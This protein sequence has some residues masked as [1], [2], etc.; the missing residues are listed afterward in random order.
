[1]PSQVPSVP[2][3]E[4]AVVAQR[5]SSVV[6]GTFEQTPSVVAPGNAHDLHVP[7]QS[8]A[9][10]TPCR[11]KPVAHSLS[12]P[13]P[14]P[15]ALSTH[16]LPL[17][18]AGEAQSVELVACE[19]LVLQTRLFESHANDPGQVPVVDGRQ[20]PAPSQVR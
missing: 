5:V 9:Q 12:V 7:W 1:M 20:V 3:V 18:V 8:L 13:Q 4:V 19:Q 14:A 16:E 6:A 15:L 10:Q 17:Q 2:Q 11:Q